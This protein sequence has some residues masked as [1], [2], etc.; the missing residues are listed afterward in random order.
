[1]IPFLTFKHHL[2]AVYR[3]NVCHRI[4]RRNELGEL[5]QIPLFRC[6]LH[7]ADSD[8]HCT[9]IHSSPLHS[10]LKFWTLMFS[11]QLMNLGN[12]CPR[13]EIFDDA[14]ISRKTQTNKKATLA[15][16]FKH[17]F[18]RLHIYVQSDK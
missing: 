9:Q 17:T 5:R 12:I 14:F 13:G 10:P 18:I 11:L 16:Y 3:Y 15:I 4:S 2:L 8:V 7:C 1:M 6:A